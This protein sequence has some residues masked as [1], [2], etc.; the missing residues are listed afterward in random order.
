MSCYILFATRYFIFTSMWWILCLSPYHCFLPFRCI[1]TLPALTCRCSIII[2]PNLGLMFWSSY[3]ISICNSLDTNSSGGSCNAF[4]AAN[5]LL[6]IP[7]TVAA[8]SMLS[9]SSAVPYDN[10]E[11]EVLYAGLVA[12]I[13]TLWLSLQVRLI[14][15]VTDRFTVKLIS[16]YCLCYVLP[17]RDAFVYFF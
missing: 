17:L 1:I 10:R 13:S 6:S 15:K 7:I 16:I 2:C 3:I 5:G 9:E 14:N 8:L 12:G 11:K 4:G